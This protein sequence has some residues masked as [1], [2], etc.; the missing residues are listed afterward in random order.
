MAAVTSDLSPAELLARFRGEI[1]CSRPAYPNVI[2]VHVR[3]AR[4]DLWRFLTFEANYFPSDPHDF[5]G[6]NV[7]AADIDAPSGKV[8]IGFSDGSALIVVPFALDPAEVDES[9]ESWQLFT[10]DGFVL[11]YGPGEHWLLKMAGDPV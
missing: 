8:T 4:G 3:D 2:Q 9:Y 5:L 10:P 11:N 1:V 6:K 7:V